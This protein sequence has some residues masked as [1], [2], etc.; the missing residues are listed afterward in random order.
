MSL[1]PLPPSLAVFGPAVKVTEDW[2]AGHDLTGLTECDARVLTEEAG[3]KIRVIARDGVSLPS[4]ADFRAKRI[5]VKLT[6]GRVSRVET[7]G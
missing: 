3:L 4:R 1:P 2:L 5:N 6:D 7:I